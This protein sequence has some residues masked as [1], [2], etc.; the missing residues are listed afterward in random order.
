MCVAALCGIALVGIVAYYVRPKKT[1]W[2]VRQLRNTLRKRVDPALDDR[3][4]HFHKLAYNAGRRGTLHGSKADLLDTSHENGRETELDGLGYGKDVIVPPPYNHAEF[5]HALAMNV[6]TALDFSKI[7]NAVPG[8]TGGDAHEFDDTAPVSAIGTPLQNNDNFLC[9]ELPPIPTPAK[10][11]EYSKLQKNGHLCPKVSTPQPRVPKHVRSREKTIRGNHT[12]TKD[13]WS[14]EVD[15]VPPPVN[16]IKSDTTKDLQPRVP[17]HARSRE[18]TIRGNHTDTKDK[19]SGE[20]DPVPPP[21]NPIKSDTTKDLQPRVPKHA[22]SREKTIRGNHTDTK[23]QWSGEVDPVPPPVNPIKSDTTKDLQPRVPKHARSR[24]K[25][26]RG[27]HTDTKD[28]WSGEVDPV[29]PPA[30]PMKYKNYEDLQRA[31]NVSGST[32]VYVA[33]K[34]SHPCAHQTSQASTGGEEQYYD[35]VGGLSHLVS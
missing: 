7:Y 26:I 28:K 10:K 20:V 32:C 15:P 19:W 9:G 1:T 29:P 25:T 33:D 17:K 21:V 6:T 5:K 31:R 8:S 4:A 13:K 14:G 11:Y 24:E 35:I 27:N 3:H 22:R 30:N 16:P 2:A 12:D 34:H 18:K 23:D